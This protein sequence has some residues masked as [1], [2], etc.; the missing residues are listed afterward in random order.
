MAPAARSIV[1]KFSLMTKDIPIKMSSI[2]K[3]ERDGSN[4]RH[5][6]LDFLSY[7]GFIPDVVDYVTEEKGEESSADYKQDFADVVNCI[8]HWNID[9]ELSLSLQGINSP[10]AR[11]EELRK[12]FSGV[13]FAARQTALKELCTMVYNPK[14][15]AFDKHVMDMRAKRDHMA[16]I[17]VNISDDVFGL[18]LSN[19][20]PSDFPNIASTFENRILGDE[21]HVVT[22]SDVMRAMGAA[23]VAYRRQS[24][25]KEVLKVS[26]KPRFGGGGQ[27]TRSCYWCDIKGHT[28]RECKKK[29]EHDRLKGTSSTTSKP[30]S[31]VVKAAE[32]EADMAEAGFAPWDDP[33][34]VTVSPLDMSIESDYGVFDTGAT[35]AVFN[36]RRHFTSFRK[37]GEIP[38][39]MADGSR[40]GMITGVGSVEIEFFDGDGSCLKL[41]KVYLCEQMKHNLISGVAI[42]DDSM[43]FATDTSGLY[44]T[45]KSGERVNAGRMGRKWVFRVCGTGVSAYI[46]ES[47]S[48]WHQRLGHPSERVLRQMVARQSC[49]GLPEKLSSTVPCE[50]CA[51]AKSTKSSSLSSTLRTYDAPLQLVVEDLCGPFQEKSVG[52]ASYFLQIRDAHTTF[53]KIYTINNKYDVTSLVKRYI[54]EAERLTGFKVIRW[55]NDGGGEFMN[56]ELSEN[57]SKLGI[58]VEKTLPYFHEQ[59]GV[60]ERSNQTIQ[61]IMRCVL[62]GSDLPKSF[63]AMAVAAAGYLHN[64]TINTNT[65]TVTPQEMFMKVKPQVDNLR[66]FGSW[67]WV[68]IPV[69]KRKKLDHRAQKAQFVGYLAGSKGWTFWDPSSN[70]F[71]ESAHARWLSE[72]GDTQH[73][74]M[75]EANSV[76][77]PDRHGTLSKIL[78][79][80]E[81]VEGQLLEALEVTYE[82]DDGDITRSVREQDQ[83]VAEIFAMAA[84]LSQKIPRSYKAAMKSEDS[85]LWREACE[86]EIN[87]L[88]RMKVWEET[89]LPAGK[90]AVSSKW[91]LGKKHDANGVVTKY[92]ARFVVRGFDQR[93]GIDF[94]ETFAPTARFASLMIIFAIAVKKG[95]PLRGFDVVSAYPHSPIDEEIYIEPPDGF[96]CSTTGK[97]LLLRRALYRTKQAARCWWKFFSKVLTGMGCAFCV[98]DQSLYVLRYK[99]DVAILWIH[100]D[101]GQ[102]CGSSLEIFSYIKRALEKSFDLVWQE[103]VEQIVGIK[104]EHKEEGLFLS[105]PH[106]TENLIRDRGFSHSSAST[107]MVAGLQLETAAAGSVPVDASQYLSII[108]SLSYLAVGTRADI[109]YAVNYLARFS[110]CPQKDHWTALKHLL[111]YLNATKNDGLWFKYGDVNGQLEV[112]CDAN[113]GGKPLDPRTGM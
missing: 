18:F 7:I 49:N 110:A 9:R 75:T 107:P 39:K 38:V 58:V 48:L 27:E 34:E 19:S 23:D 32:V 91:V 5:W 104:V 57:L 94:H 109:A 82:L 68:H 47:Y 77:E 83:L 98:G 87:M 101:D 54:A 108:G 79:A 35:H 50:I 92:K 76:P 20:V 67:A 90:R 13:S 22:S 6:E 21:G 25:V 56:A 40:G 65:G 69:E 11:M 12:Q 1:A 24:S 46:S 51:D 84:G 74:P 17:G 86:R 29:K 81:C 16:R 102:L 80:A 71:L 111:R 43:K 64:R 95:W 45:S 42:Y 55:R 53:V 88:R 44:I 105:Q 33:T 89:D 31:K 106:L 14:L 113:W 96:P 8:I 61:S 15:T 59:A 103:K 73:T 97:V 2:T 26:V 62:F 30:E 36:S 70:T 37:T 66:I 52:G 78:N 63:W 4:Y 3:L 72:D 10:F 41:A 28:I 100:V 99:S 93:E 112:F 60:I 85:G